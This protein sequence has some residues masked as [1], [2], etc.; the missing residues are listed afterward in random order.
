[1]VNSDVYIG[2]FNIT[3]L[4]SLKWIIIFFFNIDPTLL[5]FLHLILKKNAK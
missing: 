3:L 5:V 1:M 2:D 4:S